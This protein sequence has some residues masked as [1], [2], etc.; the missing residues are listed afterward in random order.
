IALTPDL[1][2]GVACGWIDVQVSGF[3]NR[4]LDRQQVIAVHETGHLFGAPHCDDVGNGSGG[5]LQGYVMCSGEKHEHYPEQF[6]WH[7]TSIAK[8]SSHWK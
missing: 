4:D 2:G 6:V 8:M 7:S 1:A 5:S 3:I